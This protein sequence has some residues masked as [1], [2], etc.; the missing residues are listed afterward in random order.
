MTFNKSKYL[1]NLYPKEKNIN[2]NIFDNFFPFLNILWRNFY[3]QKP[4]WKG[5]GI[6]DFSEIGQNLVINLVKAV[7]KDGELLTRSSGEST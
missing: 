6:I 4:A 3:L 7:G 1:F 5:N 2:Q